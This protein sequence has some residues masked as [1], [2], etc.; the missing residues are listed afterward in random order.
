MVVPVV[1]RKRYG[2]QR[3]CALAGFGGGG[4]C[5]GVVGIELFGE[6]TIHMKVIAVLDIG[7]II[8][9]HLFV[10]LLVR[11]AVDA[12]VR[13]NV[14]VLVVI[15]EIFVQAILIVTVADCSHTK[16]CYPGRCYGGS[17]CSCTNGFSGA[18]CLELKSQKFKP[19]IERIN[20]TFT[21]HSF[22]KNK[23]A[24]N[25]MA[26]AT[27]RTDGDVVWTNQNKF[28][29]LEFDLEAV[30]DTKTVFPDN[31]PEPSYIMESKLGIVAASVKIIHEK[32]GTNGIYTAKEKTL[33]CPG[34]S[35]NQPISDQRF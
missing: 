2:I 21:Y 31:P 5:A 15:Q 30:V 9:T 7:D 13:S 29:Q 1:D 35:T 22:T 8:V 23:D 17:G 25:Y 34:V 24:Y 20:S 14:L 33:S 26:D 6:F 27:N 3:A 11:T 16:P 19:L 28:N 18:S 4:L 12:P 10:A 32:L